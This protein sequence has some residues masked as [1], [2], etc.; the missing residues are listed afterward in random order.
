MAN[1]NS[2]V[3]NAKI[4]KKDEF[5]TQLT[6]IEKELKHYK[7]QFKNKIVFCNCDD[8]EYSNFWKYFYLNFDQLELKKLISTHYES[9]V[10]TYKLEYDGSEVIKTGLSQNGDFRSPECLE[11][12]DSS[13]IVVTNPPFSLFRDYITTLM[14]HNKKFIIIG[15]QNSIGYK[16][17]FPYFKNDEL[18]LGYGFN[19][20]CAHFINKY[21]EDTASDAD[22]K[23]GMI[24]VSG[25]MWFT[26]LEVTKRHEE[27]ILY[28]KYDPLEYP[29]YDNYDAIEVS[30]SKEIPYDYNGVMGVPIT[31][32]PK[33]NPDQFEIIGCS[34]NGAVDDEYKLPHFKK[35]NEPYI[36]GKKVY[37]RIFIRRK[38]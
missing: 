35:H 15:N 29:K 22:H 19:R 32:M 5:F 17:V 25:V 34:D 7:E 10:P 16:E 8:P 31:F 3:N 37:K 13:D 6:D 4:N 27:M 23:E 28:K 20:N 14:E 26:N 30:S 18:W 38:P 12:L 9:D 1:T 11:I 36:N 24:R 21:Y 2:R 33:Y